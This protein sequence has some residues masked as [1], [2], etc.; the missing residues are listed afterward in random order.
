MK[1]WK[2]FDTVLNLI[3][4][5]KKRP[6]RIVS[7]EKFEEGFIVMEECDVYFGSHYTKKEMN[8]LIKELS[9]FVNS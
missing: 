7:V 1:H 5:D 8:E 2:K 4:K 6:H 9:E 3:G